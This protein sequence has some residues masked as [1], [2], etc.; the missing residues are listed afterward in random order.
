MNQELAA[1]ET[2][3]LIL[4]VNAIGRESGN[5]S[6]VD[7]RTTPWLQD[8]PSED[9]WASWDITYRDVVVLD[10]NLEVTD[11]VN[12]TTY[13]LRE[14]ENYTRLLDAVLAARP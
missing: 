8:I 9:V 5:S 13:D 7:G 11:I 4:G 3:A 1:L 14:P 2:S 12:T 10:A 6:I